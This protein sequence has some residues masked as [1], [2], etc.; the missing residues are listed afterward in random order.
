MSGE[1]IVDVFFYAFNPK[2]VIPDE[3]RKHIRTKSIDEVL[4]EIKR[5]LGNSE[6]RKIVIYR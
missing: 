4:E 6:I 5:M 1:N 2:A 3:Q